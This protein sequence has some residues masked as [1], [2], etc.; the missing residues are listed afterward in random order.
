MNCREIEKLLQLYHDGELSAEETRLV[1]RHLSKCP[2]CRAA[3]AK[4]SALDALIKDGKAEKVP[5]PGKHYWQSFSHRVIRRLS[6][7]RP[8]LRRPTS[9]TKL[10]RFG[11][12]PYLSAGA[13]IV[14]AL[15]V[16]FTMLKEVPAGFTEEDVSAAKIETKTEE[17]ESIDAIE[18]ETGPEEKNEPTGIVFGAEI[19]EKA[20]AED[21][22]GHKDAE[23]PVLS[24]P[25][26]DT[27]VKPSGDYNEIE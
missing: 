17:G 4:L 9:R 12:I 14:L 1:E 10:F 23:E 2:D 13:A 15:V 18:T 19:E 27:D 20:E 25:R 3:L 22:R 26:A 11:L 24:L 7:H 5:D 6:A 16:S 21:D 8:S